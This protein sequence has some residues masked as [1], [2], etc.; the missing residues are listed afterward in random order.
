[1]CLKLSHKRALM[2]KDK[3]PVTVAIPVYNGE[4]FLA[5]AIQSVLNQDILPR[6][7]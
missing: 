7:Y 3:L 5:K 4:R 6:S 1:M 2:N